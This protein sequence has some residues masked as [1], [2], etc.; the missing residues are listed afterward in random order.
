[1]NAK[2][3]NAPMLSKCVPAVAFAIFAISSS[4]ALAAAPTIT[5]F[6]PASG[7][8]NTAVTITGTGFAAPATVTFNGAAA[9]SVTVKSSTTILTS[10][11]TNGSTGK[12]A[13]KTPGGTVVS[14]AV[15]T[16]TAGVASSPGIASPTAAATIYFSGFDAEEAVDLYFDT[17]DFA[18][19]VTT[20]TGVG[21]VAVTIPATATPGNHFISAVGRKSGD[22]AQ[23][24]FTVR[25]DWMELGFRPNR[26]GR[27]PVE[28]TLSPDNVDQLDESWRTP[29]N[30]ELY[31]SPA[32]VAGI[33]YESFGDGTMRAFSEATGAQKWVYTTGESDLDAFSGAAVVNGIVYVG[34]ADGYLYALDA[35][36]GALKWRYL[37]GDEVSSSPVVKGGIV[38]FGSNDFYV[39]ALNAT[40]GALI[41]KYGTGGFVSSP[42]VWNGMVFIGSYDNNVYALNAA[43]GAV[44]WSYTTGAQ[45]TASPTVVGGTLYVG[46]YDAYMYAFRA[47]TGQLRWRYQTG[48]SI[49]GNAAFEN[50]LVYFGSGD[51]NVYALSASGA[52][53]WSFAVPTGSYVGQNACVA[54]GVV[55]IGDGSYTYALDASYGELYIALPGAASLGGPI[56]V[57]GAL[58]VPDN[59]TGSIV[60]YTLNASAAEPPSAAP[61]PAKLRHHPLR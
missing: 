49:E 1:L 24:V 44:I 11:P 10:V 2:V 56:A 42:A 54:N 6:T 16:V 55:Y 3:H 58:I 45:V 33:I 18:L 7:K 26:R 47:Q 29:G 13:V 61:D 17:T 59:Q 57:N 41:W 53:R 43:T 38:Y 20:G 40:T 27:N 15:F 31:N 4:S 9:I 22:A 52:L 36:T 5:S 39:Y 19:G 32:D 34:F 23:A 48:G 25:T 46:S 50:G 30:Y 21:N 35:D 28:N 51:G 12:V 14:T 60:R 37:T 8:L